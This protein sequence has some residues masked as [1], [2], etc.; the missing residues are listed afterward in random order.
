MIYINENK[1]RILIDGNEGQLIMQVELALSE[2]LRIEFKDSGKN[3]SFKLLEFI[4][5]KVLHYLSNNI[6]DESIE[7]MSYLCLLP[8]EEFLK[9]ID[10]LEGN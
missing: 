7:E 9:E 1:N 8:K 2:I 4:Y 5:S 3:S 6:L 10:K